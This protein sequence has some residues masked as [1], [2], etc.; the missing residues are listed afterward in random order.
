MKPKLFIV[1]G[2]VIIFLLSAC[3]SNKSTDYSELTKAQENG[4]KIF[5]SNCSSCHGS[6]G[7]G[8]GAAARALAPPPTNLAAT[9]E[10]LDDD[11][12]YT[13]ISEGGIGDPYNSQMPAWKSIL[14]EDQIWDVIAYIRTL[15]K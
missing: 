5:L 8:D 4:R 12:L 9:H 1:V 14:A 7:K 2:L 6:S 3:S 15:S 10:K 13:R 11:Y